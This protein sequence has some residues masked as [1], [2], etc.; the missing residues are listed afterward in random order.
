VTSPAIGPSDLP[1]L[2]ASYVDLST[3]Q[4]IAGVKTF[5][6]PIAG[7]VTGN[8]G[9]ATLAGA[10]ALDPADCAFGFAVS[11]DAQGNLTCAAIKASDL[12]SLSAD[13]V[14][15]TTSQTVT[16]A[17]IFTGHLVTAQSSSVQQTISFSNNP[18]FNAGNGNNFKLTLTGDVA[19]SIVANASAGQVLRFLL[20]QDATG[21]RAFAWPTNFK[22]G[23]TL[24]SL[25]NTCSLQQFYFDGTD[26][27]ALTTGVIN[28]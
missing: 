26:A 20:C 12:P 4:T 24:G 2:A 8:A 3:A 25:P 15:L 10:M 6:S 11:I 19:G 14:D 7:D 9:T 18:V 28:Q 5:S 21:G 17:K 23:M 13:Y 1:S 16:G 27:Y 22:S